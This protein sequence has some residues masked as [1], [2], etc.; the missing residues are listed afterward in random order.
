MKITIEKLNE[1]THLRATNESGNTIDM[2]GMP[3]IG[4]QGLGMRPMEILLTSLG[5]CTSMDVISILQK[6]HQH[7]SIYHLEV[8]GIREQDK[9]PALFKTIQ[10]TFTVK[11]DHLDPKKVE[12]AV[13]LS[14]EKYCSVAKILEPT[15][16][17]T[18]HIQ[19]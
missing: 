5:G 16:T 11:G 1:H 3:S 18:Y 9:E 4:G 17:I 7:I 2:D 6:Q 14:M 13:S 10:L 12:R 15:A 8:D 19:E